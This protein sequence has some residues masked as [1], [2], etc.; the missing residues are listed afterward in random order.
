MVEA[1]LKAKDP[2]ASIWRNH[3]LKWEKPDREWTA[4]NVDGCV[5][6]GNDKAGCAGLMRDSE[7]KWRGGFFCNI[8]TDNIAIAKGW[9]ILKGIEWAWDGGKRKMEVRTD[10]HDMFKWIEGGNLAQRTPKE[11]CRR[12]LLVEE[13]KLGDS[14]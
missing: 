6:Q 1:F 2:G 14:L 10:S 8:H 11:Y 5:I 7:G 9:A 13:Q 12:V 4:I 3:R